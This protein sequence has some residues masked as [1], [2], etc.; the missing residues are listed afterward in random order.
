M[1]C[2]LIVEAE[3]EET[4]DL[5]IQNSE[6][7]KVTV[8]LFSTLHVKNIRQHLFVSLQRMGAAFESLRKQAEADQQ[9]MLKCADLFIYFSNYYKNVL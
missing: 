3:R 6:T 5:F 9:D 1:Y 8:V 4:H 7:I 2:V